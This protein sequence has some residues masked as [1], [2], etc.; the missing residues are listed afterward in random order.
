MDIL[1]LILLKQ[2]SILHGSIGQAIPNPGVVPENA[3]LAPWQDINTG[4]RL[5]LFIMVLQEQLQIEYLQLLGVQF[6]MF[7]C[8][9][10]LH[11]SQVV[12]HEGSNKIEMF[13]QDKPPLLNMEWWSCSTRIGRCYIYKCR[14]CN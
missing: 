12:M 2:I 4:V 11:T 8:T 14:Y 9:N 10:L 7:S 6:A 3:I 5:D 13:I 1:L